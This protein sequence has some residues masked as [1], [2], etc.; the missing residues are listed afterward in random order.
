MTVIHQKPKT[1][2]VPSDQKPPS[3]PPHSGSDFGPGGPLLNIISNDSLDNSNML[4]RQTEIDLNNDSTDALLETENLNVDNLLNEENV[5]GL[6]H[7]NFDI[8]EST[9][10]FVCDV[11][12]K[13]FGK[14][15]LLVQ[16]MRL[17]T[18]QYTCLCCYKVNDFE[19]L[20]LI[21]I[22]K[23]MFL[24]FRKERITA[25]SQLQR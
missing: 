14:L 7:F 2:T 4:L 1:T 15:P 11:C 3:S 23:I 8:D 5:R 21:K 24:D 16:H 22:L 10:Q 19:D 17:H 20:T 12:L 13:P 18:G 25:L 6:D 9:D